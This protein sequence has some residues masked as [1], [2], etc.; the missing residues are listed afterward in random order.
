M[1][2]ER[3]GGGRGSPWND[4]LQ[5]QREGLSVLLQRLGCLMRGWMDGSMDGW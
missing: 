1:D 4:V 5:K 3:E 2:G